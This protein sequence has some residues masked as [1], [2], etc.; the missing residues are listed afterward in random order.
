MKNI[1]V[2]KCKIPVFV[3]SLFLILA[4]VAFFFIN[5]F[6]LGVDFEGGVSQVIEFS[7]DDVSV[8]RVREALQKAEQVSTRVQSV[9]SESGNCFSLRTPA[10][11]DEEQESAEKAINSALSDAF[12]A[13]SFTVISSDFIGSKFSKS[14][15]TSSVLA[16]V[17]ALLLILLYVWFRFK[18]VYSVA[19]VV[20]LMHDILILLSFI[21]IANIEISSITI[22]GIL[23]IIGYSLNNT[24][25]IFDRVR[26]NVN[27]M[28]RQSF[29]HLIDTSITQSITRTIFSSLTTL[30]V[31]IPLGLIVQNNDIKMFSLVLSVGIVIGIYSSTFVAGNLLSLI[32][33]NKVGSLLKE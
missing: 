14:L 8:Q 20:T 11:N 2:S 22:A 33:K 15:I 13:D 31:I 27:I 9:G 30:A 21:L 6:N 19:A 1:P 5:H 24:I 10:N 7:I 4:G 32:S 25:V 17:V 12:G 26:E 29:S 16:V 28:D 3:I 23:T 18:L